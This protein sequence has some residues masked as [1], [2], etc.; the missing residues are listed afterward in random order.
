M[1]K[2]F[3]SSSSSISTNEGVKR[4]SIITFL[5]LFIWLT[6]FA[7]CTFA[8]EDIT[9]MIFTQPFVFADVVAVI[10]YVLIAVYLILSGINLW[11]M[12]VLGVKMMIIFGLMSAVYCVVLGIR[13]GL[14][15]Y[16]STSFMMLGLSAIYYF[17]IWPELTK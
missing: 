12:K 7:F 15:V 6:A 13:T 8:F 16:F 2:E 17:I 9:R 11:R 10:P 14:F 4:S 5:C 3:V 1:Q